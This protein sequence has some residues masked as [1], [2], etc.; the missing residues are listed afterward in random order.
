M[1]REEFNNLTQEE[2]VEKACFS[3]DPELL[4][5]LSTDENLF[6]RAFVVT[7][8]CTSEKTLQKMKENDEDFI[9]RLI[10]EKR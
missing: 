8:E 7:N 1:E 9:K 2:R 5:F 6:V 10:D 3:T 4:D